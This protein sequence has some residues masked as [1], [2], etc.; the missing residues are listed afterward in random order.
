MKEGEN[1]IKKI[2]IEK[3]VDIAGT[4][5]GI[6]GTLLSL[7]ANKKTAAKEFENLVKKSSE[8]K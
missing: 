1:M 7:W 6:T 3:L 5:L 2:E 8:N 4:A